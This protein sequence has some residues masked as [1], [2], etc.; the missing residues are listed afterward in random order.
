MKLEK[1]IN[2]GWYMER[3]P[4]SIHSGC[5]VFYMGIC[6]KL[7]TIIQ[8]LANDD[9]YIDTIDLDEEDC[10]DLAYTFT[11]Y[12]EDPVNDIGFWRS[13]YAFPKKNF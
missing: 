13:L 3:K 12:F 6:R 2:I 1:F 11:A 8:E 9:E 4:Y 5:D 10:R 7:Y